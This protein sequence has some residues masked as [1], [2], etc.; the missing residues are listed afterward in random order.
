LRLDDA[1]ELAELPWE[2]LYSRTDQRH[3]ALSEQTPIVRFLS[4]PNPPPALLVEP[5]LNILVM[6]SN[7]R[8]YTQLEVEQEFATIY[9]GLAPFRQ[10]NQVTIDRL[11]NARPSVLQDQ[12]RRKQY[13]VFH[14]IGHGG[15]DEDTNDAVLIMERRNGEGRAIGKEYLRVLLDHYH[16][17]LAILNSCE[18]ARAGKTDPFS[19]VAQNLVQSGI[20]AVIAMQHKITDEA[21]ILFASTFYGATADGYPVDASLAEARKAIYVSRN[22]TE[23]GTPVLFMRSPEGRIFQIDQP[24]E[25]Q[26]RQARIESL[27]RDAKTAIDRRDYAGAIEKLQSILTLEEEA[28]GQ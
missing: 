4:L 12:L 21:A 22:P 17:R 3:F 23:W 6:V 8:G 14:F 2:Y 1:P 9:D 24:F 16:L 7:P 10:T 19:G 26:I 25:E 5:P 28:T 20:P 13:H 15:F 11:P 18:G 27:S